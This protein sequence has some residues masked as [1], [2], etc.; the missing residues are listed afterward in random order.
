MDNIFDD[1]FNEFF[2]NNESENKNFDEAKNDNIKKLMDM[3]NDFGHVSDYNSPT[4]LDAKLGEPDKIERFEED[5]FHFEKRTWNVYGGEIVCVA[6]LDIPLDEKPTKEKS[7]DEQLEEAIEN[8]EYEIAANIR[9][10]IKKEKKRK[11][12]S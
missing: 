5:G 11:K 9:D 8:E 10:L 3:L 4:E 12:K 6:M 1:L 7:L 2:K